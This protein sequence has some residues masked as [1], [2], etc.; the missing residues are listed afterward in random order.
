MTAVG[1]A[2]ET[3]RGTPKPRRSL[4]VPSSPPLQRVG[5]KYAARRLCQVACGPF[6]FSASLS[7]RRSRR[8]MEGVDWRLP[9]PLAPRIMLC[10]SRQSKAPVH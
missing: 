6:S 8:G 7:R 3:H 1:E 10:N 2:A 9:P 4:P 5:R